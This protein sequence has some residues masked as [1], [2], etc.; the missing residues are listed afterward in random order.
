MS[1]RISRFPSRNQSATALVNTNHWIGRE[2]STRRGFHLIHH[3]K[4]SGKGRKKIDNDKREIHPRAAKRRIFEQVSSALPSR[5]RG[6]KQKVN[7]GSAVDRPNQQ[8]LLNQPAQ[9]HA[10]RQVPDVGVDD[11]SCVVS[12]VDLVAAAPDTVW[13]A[14]KSTY[15]NFLLANPQATKQFL[16]SMLQE[17]SLQLPNS[18]DDGLTTSRYRANARA[19]VK[20]ELPIVF[21][22]PGKNVYF[23]EEDGT[24][25]PIVV[26]CLEEDDPFLLAIADEARSL[27][28]EGSP[29][30]INEGKFYQLVATTTGGNVSVVVLQQVSVVDVRALTLSFS[31]PIELKS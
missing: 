27:L 16:L 2:K 12:P 6:K 19:N 28:E 24:L 13:T 11:A 22:A 5:L 18:E 7:S 10:N 4:M 30:K 1:K 3:S 25:E 14:F 31:P 20:N 17:N 29:T 8:A 15:E 26:W 21:D 9:R 23:K